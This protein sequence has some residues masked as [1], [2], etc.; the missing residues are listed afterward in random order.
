MGQKGKY[1]REDCGR[2]REMAD[3]GDAR[4]NCSNV[5]ADLSTHIQSG[6]NI[7][8]ASAEFGLESPKHELLSVGLVEL[9]DVDDRP[10]FILDLTSPSKTI[11][12]YYNAS[13]Q[14]IPLL[15]LKI[16]KGVIGNRANSQWLL[17]PGCVQERIA[18]SRE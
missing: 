5:A 11:P 8:T 10:V 6:T 18:N 12:V 13:L 4:V 1:K 7:T 17:E 14:E 9:L 2:H 16:G 15:E 3:L